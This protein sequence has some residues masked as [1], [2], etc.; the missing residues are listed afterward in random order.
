MKIVFQ[1]KVFSSIE[2]PCLKQMETLW[3]PHNYLN[4]AKPL[5]GGRLI[6][7]RTF[8]LST[9]EWWN[10]VKVISMTYVSY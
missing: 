6:L 5:R 4:A 7:P 2:K 9:T 8:F 10:A 1:N 3:Y